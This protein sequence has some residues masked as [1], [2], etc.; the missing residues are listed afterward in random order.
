MSPDRSDVVG[1]KLRSGAAR[2][3]RVWLQPKQG[4]RIDTS[5]RHLQCGKSVSRVARYAFQIGP[6]PQ[7]RVP[8]LPPLLPPPWDDLCHEPGRSA[9][10][11][12]GIY[13]EPWRASAGVRCQGRWRAPRFQRR[14]VGSYHDDVAVNFG[15]RGAAAHVP[16]PQ[17]GAGSRL[18]EDVSRVGRRR[19]HLVVSRGLL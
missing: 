12:G 13:H 5:G 14:P 8:T 4:S 17:Q 15:G 7:G 6:A 2:R 11:S 3:C 10:W 1:E 9:S 16:D 18:H 19:A